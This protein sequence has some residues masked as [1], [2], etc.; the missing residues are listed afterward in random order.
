MGGA[1]FGHAVLN[2]LALLRFEGDFRFDCGFSAVTRRAWL[3]HEPGVLGVAHLEQLGEGLGR[4]LLLVFRFISN[5]G[6]GVVDGLG[7]ASEF[8]LAPVY[9][10]AVCLG[11]QINGRGTGFGRTG[12][13][14]SS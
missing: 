6:E 9:E 2:P 5:K 14:L 8:L 12:L 1:Y 3:G 13:T 11:P 4:V 7:V 10:F